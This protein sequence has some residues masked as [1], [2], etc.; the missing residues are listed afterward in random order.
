MVEFDVNEAADH[1]PVLFHCWTGALRINCGID[2]P[3][4]TLTSKEL[5]RIRY[6]QSEE[7]LATLEEG[8]EACRR[9]NLGVML[10]IKAPDSWHGTGTVGP[11]VQ[12]LDRIGALLGAYGLT[13][14]SCAGIAPLYLQ[15]LRSHLPHG[16]LTPIGEAELSRL[17]ERTAVSVEGTYWFGVPRDLSDDLVARLQQSS[18]L[19]MAAINTFQYPVH[20][21]DD[22]ARSDIGRLSAVGVDAFQLDS[23][24]EHYVWS[25]AR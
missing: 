21:H 2:R 11:S 16:M 1:E 20:A 15:L 23:I 3:I 13:P 19:V 25:L 7:H 18:V 17:R 6:L 9:E 4:H 5:K 24:Y 8:L 22:V 14:A 10:D 12:F